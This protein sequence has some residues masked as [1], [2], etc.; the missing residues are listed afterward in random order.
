MERIIKFRAKMS[1]IM[2]ESVNCDGDIWVYGF[3]LEKLIGDK[4]FS[5]ITDG[6]HEFEVDKSTLGQLTWLK[7][8]NGTE[9]YEGDIVEY[10]DYYQDWETGEIEFS[11]K[12]YVV[13]YEE[14]FVVFNPIPDLERLANI[15]NVPISELADDDNKYIGLNVIGNIY[16]NPELIDE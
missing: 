4:L 14:D 7:D 1:D 12:Q 5:I 6:A 3:Y 11:L 10:Y 2:A 8:K 9:I 15:Y 16:D 13:G